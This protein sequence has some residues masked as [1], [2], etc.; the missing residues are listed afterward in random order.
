M[1]ISSIFNACHTHAIGSCERSVTRWNPL[2]RRVQHHLK[3]QREFWTHWSCTFPSYVRIVSFRDSLFEGYGHND[4]MRGGKMIWGPEITW[5]AMYAMG[6]KRRKHIATIAI[7]QSLVSLIS[8]NT[9]ACVQARALQIWH[10]AEK[11]ETNAITPAIMVG[12]WN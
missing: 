4:K 1:F 5:R 9:Y 8:V 6:L 7:G 11:R 3:T 10:N 12:N 2:W